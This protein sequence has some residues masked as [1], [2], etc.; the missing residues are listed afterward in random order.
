MIWVNIA[1]SFDPI[2]RLHMITD[3]KGHQEEYSTIHQR[4][5]LQQ[6]GTEAMHRGMMHSKDSRKIRAT[7]CSALREA[8]GV[9]HIG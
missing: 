1:L 5:K 9:F 2:L 4:Y 6:A 7:R 8:L 3:A